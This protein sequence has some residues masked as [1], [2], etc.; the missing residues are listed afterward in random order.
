MSNGET[1]LKNNAPKSA[2][3]AKTQLTMLLLKT[4]MSLLKTI[5][6]RLKNQETKLKRQTNPPNWWTT[7]RIQ[8]LSPL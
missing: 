8:M 1:W 5:S 2:K 7:K 6:T 3:K 4:T